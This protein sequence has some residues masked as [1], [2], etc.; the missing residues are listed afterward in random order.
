MKSQI[1]AIDARSIGQ[2]HTG[3]TTYWTG[4]VRGLARLD[5]DLRFLLFSNAPRPQTIPEMDRMSW[6]ELPTHN[7]RW[8]SLFRF[9]LTARRMGARVIHSQYNLSPLITHGG[10]TTIHDVSFYHE[11]EWFQ[12]RDRVLLQRFVPP[13]ARRAERVITVS[14]FSKREIHQ[15]ISG[16]GEKVVVAPNACDEAIHPVPIHQARAQIKAALGLD[17]PFMLTV[18]TRWPRKNLGLA[19]RAVDA[20]PDSL[21][22]KLVL[23]GKAGW[24]DEAPS[25][26][27]VVSGFVDNELLCAL[28]SAA[29]LYLAPAH[30]EGF[31]ITLLEAFMCGCPVLANAN[32]AHEEV[33]GGA[34]RI[35]AGDQGVWSGAIQEMLKDS[36]GRSALVAKGRER[37]KAFSWDKSAAIVEKAY[38]EILGG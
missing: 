2:D 11:P 1:V 21:P 13:S 16:L 33:V 25:S 3:D 10:V 36:A 24:G 31:G 5:S 12:P 18:G 14:E 27:A 20:L 23:T 4:L 35:A 17:G 6:I 8:W 19:L 9:P 22:H 32:G 15:F 37:V 38:R 26:R 28:Y 7:S 30:Y 29:D 34:A